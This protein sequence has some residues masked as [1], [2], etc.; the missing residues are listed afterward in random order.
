[1]TLTGMPPLS[2]LNYISSS[3]G[4]IKL[5]TAQQT[6]CVVLCYLG[7]HTLVCVLNTGMFIH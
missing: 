6:I 3:T 4:I 2:I 1:M 7:A 5:K